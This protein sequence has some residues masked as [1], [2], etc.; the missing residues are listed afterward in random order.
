MKLVLIFVVG[1]VIGIVVIDYLRLWLYVRRARKH[2]DEQRR[3]E[4]EGRSVSTLDEIIHDMNWYKPRRKK[5]KKQ[6]MEE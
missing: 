5:E 6:R 2:R 3:M 1:T 4:D